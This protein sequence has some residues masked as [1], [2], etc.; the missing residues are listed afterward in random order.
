MSSFL[1]QDW[2][3]VFTKAVAAL[4][5]NVAGVEYVEHVDADLFPRTRV[6]THLLHNLEVS[7]S[8]LGADVYY[9]RPLL[10]RII[11]DSA[12]ELS[13]ETLVITS[14]QIL[15]AG[16]SDNVL[17]VALRYAFIFRD[18]PTEPEGVTVV[19][20]DEERQQREDDEELERMMEAER[21]ELERKEQEEKEALEKAEK[22]A[23]EKAEQDRLQ[24]E[25]EERDAEAARL[26]E[27]EAAQ[28]AAQTQTQQTEEVGD[29]E[30][31]EE[32]L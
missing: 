9:A 7:K 12:P 13:G 31:P 20:T 17:N 14:P 5:I 4:K 28:K 1:N 21:L 30:F 2:Q 16:S 10:E 3:A 25:Q 24:K 29:D 32:E 11:R 19:E 18:T 26:R 6:A 23:I 22:E 15:P 8:Y 27:A